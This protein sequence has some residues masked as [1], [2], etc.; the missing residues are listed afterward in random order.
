[1]KA[2][3]DKAAKPGFE[4]I[5]DNKP[6]PKPGAAAAVA[7]DANALRSSRGAP[8]K[9]AKLRTGR[10]V[11]GRAKSK[12]MTLE[13]TLEILGAGQL[14]MDDGRKPLIND[15]ALRG[16]SPEPAKG[17]PSRFGRLLERLS[18]RLGS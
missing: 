14:Q 6:P 8:G 11:N 17:K 15:T 16:S 4:F 7:A 3:A 5:D 2:D 10:Q 1:V 9:R 13:E 18:E 12:P